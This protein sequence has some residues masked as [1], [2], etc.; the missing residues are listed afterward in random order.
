M[1]FVDEKT[2][3]MLIDD[4]FDLVNSIAMKSNFYRAAKDQ[5]IRKWGW[6]TD[7]IYIIRKWDSSICINF[8]VYIP[9]RNES[10]LDFEDIAVVNLFPMV[11]YGNSLAC[12]K[13][14]K[15]AFFYS[16]F[17]KTIQN[18]MVKGLP[19]F[20]DFD[21]PQKCLRYIKDRQADGWRNPDSPADKHCEAYFDSLP[22]ELETNKLPGI[23]TKMKIAWEY[24][25]DVSRALFD[26]DYDNTLPEFADDD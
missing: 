4:I 5:W 26:L 14:P 8:A 19:W 17:K 16:R 6:K 25:N 3:K 21:T 20:D 18:A 12:I 2:K 13:A 1:I 11:G 22:A 9:A 10:D 7:V 24:P 23:P 15:F